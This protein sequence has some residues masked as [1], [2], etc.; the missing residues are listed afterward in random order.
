MGTYIT[1][2]KPTS[3]FIDVC[4][5]EI[6]LREFVAERDTAWMRTTLPPSR[7]FMAACY[8]LNAAEAILPSLEGNPTQA[9]TLV[10]ACRVAYEHA[11]IEGRSGTSEIEPTIHRLVSRYNAS[12][13]RDSQIKSIRL[14]KTKPYFKR[15]HPGSQ[16]PCRDQNGGVD[17]L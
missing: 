3:L 16:C 1:E 17:C 9:S 15:S 6:S 5:G 7:A 4:E 11:S 14:S 8:I 13:T 10:Y 2:N 12:V